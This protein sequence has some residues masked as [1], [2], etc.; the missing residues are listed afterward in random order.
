MERGGDEGGGAFC[1]EVGGARDFGKRGES[2]DG[3]NGGKSVLGPC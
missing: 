3:L 2:D 1:G